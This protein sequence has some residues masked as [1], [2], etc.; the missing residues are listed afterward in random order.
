MLE[1]VDP[2]EDV[3]EEL[4]PALRGRDNRFRGVYDLMLAF[5][6]G[7]WN[8]V[9]KVAHRIGVQ[10]TLL[11]DCYMRATGEADELV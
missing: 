2:S 3:V 4:D 7:T 11:P 8:A 1:N 5:E 10:E 6:R 9:S